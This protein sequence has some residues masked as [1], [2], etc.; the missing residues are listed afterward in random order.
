[1]ALMRTSRKATTGP[2][3]PKKNTS[4]NTGG[5][6]GGSGAMDVL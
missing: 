5:G 1:M 6:G 3:D 4:N 2:G